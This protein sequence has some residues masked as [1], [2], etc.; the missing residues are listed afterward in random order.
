[1]AAYRDGATTPAILAERLSLSPDNARQ[2]MTRLRATLAKLG[3][4]LEGEA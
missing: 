2:R 4:E 3:E 1:L